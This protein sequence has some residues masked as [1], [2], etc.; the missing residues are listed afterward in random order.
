MW[1]PWFLISRLAA[2]AGQGLGD[3]LFDAFERSALVANLRNAEASAKIPCSG[4]QFGE[5]RKC[6]DR[7]TVRRRDPA[8]ICNQREAVSLRQRKVA[9]EDAGSPARVEN[10]SSGDSVPNNDDL[11]PMRLNGCAVDRRLMRVE[12][13]DERVHVR[14][15]F[16]A[17]DLGNNPKCKPWTNQFTSNGP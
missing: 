10:L 7:R 15:L 11:H 5:R 17:P 3:G 1:P 6:E 9:D 13:G 8:Q 2:H 4:A 16:F 12:F 14:V